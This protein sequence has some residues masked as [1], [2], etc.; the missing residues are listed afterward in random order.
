MS[1][2]AD[3]QPRPKELRFSSTN[4]TIIEFDGPADH[5]VRPCPP[6]RL[7]GLMAIREQY[8]EAGLLPPWKGPTGENEPPQSTPADPQPVPKV[9]PRVS[10][11]STVIEIDGPADHTVHPRSPEHLAS[12]LAV[13]QLYV[14]AGLLPPWTGPTPEQAQP[15]A[16]SPEKKAS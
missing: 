9:R 6:E 12:L 5:T 10:R 8:V 11:E 2:P 16:P 14:D 7:A 15:D 3:P 13:R 4:C 1:T